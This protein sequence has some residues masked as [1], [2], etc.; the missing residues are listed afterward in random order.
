MAGHVDAAAALIQ[1]FATNGCIVA[2]PQAAATKLG[3]LIQGGPSN[4]TVIA[5][6]D[7]TLTGAK[8]AS[9]HQVVAGVLSEPFRDVERRLH[10]PELPREAVEADGARLARHAGVKEALVAHTL[11]D[12]SLVQRATPARC[13]HV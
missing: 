3:A 2:D 10:Q 11:L 6:F 4:L 13:E 12:C 9:A 5:D 8:S 1:Q 7:R